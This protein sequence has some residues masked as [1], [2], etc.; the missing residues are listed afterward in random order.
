M[1]NGNVF[2]LL[3]CL[4]LS[5]Y[6]HAEFL[7]LGTPNMGGTGCPQGTSSIAVSPDQSAISILFDQYV[8]EAGGSKSFDRKSCNFAIPVQ[9]PQGYSI[10]VV[11]VDFRGF[12]LLPD[13]ASATLNASYFIPG[14]SDEIRSTRSFYGPT[15]DE[16]TS[17]D[18]V[19]VRGQVW[20][21]CGASAI[22]RANTSILLRTNAAR[23][24]A[25]VTVDSADISSGVIYHLQWR[26]CH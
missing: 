18:N 24:D 15:A 7:K 9:V 3:L 4:L 5:G 19:V 20:S 1:K 11:E 25:M 22:L 13:G 12:T 10:S 6:A 16:Y 17:S 8:A 26:R 14:K 21:A 23:E 2:T